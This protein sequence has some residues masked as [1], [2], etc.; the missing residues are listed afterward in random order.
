MITQYKVKWKEY[1]EDEN[2][3]VTD[4]YD[5]LVKA[6]VAGELSLK[7]YHMQGHV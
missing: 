4:I 3:W 1:P 6:Y 2:S 5:D 7:L